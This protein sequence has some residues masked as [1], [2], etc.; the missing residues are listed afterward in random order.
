MTL[1]FSHE[2]LQ[3]YQVSL[4]LMRWLTSNAKLDA[5]PKSEIRRLDALCTSIVLNVAEGNG[6]HSDRDQGRFCQIAHESAVKMAA[7]L[8]VCR[9]AEVQSTAAVDEGKNLL[10]R[11]CEMTSVMSRGRRR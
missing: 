4:D 3:V 1:Q 6:R 11:I 7:H 10:L 8:D 2:G 5:L 9:H